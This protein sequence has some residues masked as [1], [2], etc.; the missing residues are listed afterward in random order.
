MR[1]DGQERGNTCAFIILREKRESRED[2]LCLHCDLD[3][4][5]TRVR[6][7]KLGY[8]RYYTERERQE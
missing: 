6:L 4:D 3:P 7:C 2:D 8:T 1:D 5:S